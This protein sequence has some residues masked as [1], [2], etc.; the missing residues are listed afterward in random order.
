MG[1]DDG[2]WDEWASFLNDVLQAIEVCSG[3]G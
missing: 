3:W 1:S 2:V